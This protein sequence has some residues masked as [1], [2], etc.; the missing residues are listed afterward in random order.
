MAAVFM[1][2]GYSAQDASNWATPVKPFKI[3]ENFCYVGASDL[4][5]YLFVSQAGLIVLDGGDAATGRQI[6][7]NI[8]TLGFDPA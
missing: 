5:A 8:R 3:G 1:S 4:A 6:V 7:A 2:G